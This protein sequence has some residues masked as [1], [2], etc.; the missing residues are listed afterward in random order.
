MEKRDK[1]PP[2]SINE[3]ADRIQ[4]AGWAGFSLWLIDGGKER[5]MGCL[6]DPRNWRDA[7]DTNLWNW[8]PTAQAVLEK[9]VL[10]AEK[11]PF[12][13]GEDE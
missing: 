4:A 7:H 11:H 8:Q 13:G 10:L 3:A 9:L 6:R 12:E 2:L 5:Y 1:L